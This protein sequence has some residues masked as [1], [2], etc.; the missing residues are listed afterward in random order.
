MSRK[1]C[2][3][4]AGWGFLAAGG[5]AGEGGAAYGEGGGD[6]GEYAVAAVEQGGGVRRLGGAPADARV[7]GRPCVRGRLRS[8]LRRVHDRHPLQSIPRRSQS[9]KSRGWCG[10]WGGA[11]RPGLGGLSRWGDGRSRKRRAADRCPV[12]GAVVPH[13]LSAPRSTR[14]CVVIH[15]MV[16]GVGRGEGRDGSRDGRD[17]RYG[18]QWVAW[19]RS[20]RA[21]PECRRGQPP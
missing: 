7:A 13:R 12:T 5:G 16:R 15:A 3:R 14:R 10:S 6:G 8:R 4:G 1:S 11:T 18:A 2:T 17:S 21:V 20:L 19:S 9:A